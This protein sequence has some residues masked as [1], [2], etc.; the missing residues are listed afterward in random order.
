MFGS[1]SEQPNLDS[2]IEHISVAQSIDALLV[3]PATADVVAKFAQGIAND[4]LTTLYLATAAPVV[5]A[6]AMNINMWNHPPTQASVEIL[7]R[8]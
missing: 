3:A 5:V 8:V 4:F 1:Q 7:F 2:A 6:P